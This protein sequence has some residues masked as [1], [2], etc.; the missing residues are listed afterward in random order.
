MCQSYP[1]R[2]TVIICFLGWFI[3]CLNPAVSACK[4]KH[5]CDYFSFPSYLSFPLKPTTIYL[6]STK[7]I[8]AFFFNLLWLQNLNYL[9]DM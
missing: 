6:A 8:E 1:I 3:S 5:L 4:L 7:E 9:K 2:I